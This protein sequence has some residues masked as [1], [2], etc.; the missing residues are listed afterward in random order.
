[1]SISNSLQCEGFPLLRNRDDLRQRQRPREIGKR[2]LDLIISTLALIV[3]AP[4]LLCLWAAIR[5]DSPGPAVFRQRRVGRGEKQF[6]CFK[7]RTMHYKADEDLHRE[8]IH[9]LWTG[10][11]ISND[12]DVPYKIADDPRT[13]RVGRWLRRTSLDELPQL[14]NVLRGEMSLVGPRPAI[15][16][17]LQYFGDCRQKRHEVK[18][19]ITGVW[20]VR[21]RA[22]VPPA[23]MLAMD[24]EYAMTWSI[25]TD[26]KLI[27]LT[28]PAVLMR[29]GAR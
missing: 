6:I 15:P 11:R 5:L 23:A 17:E 29:Y 13:T 18:P 3:L 4:V 21:G 9:R 26:L 1:M 20:Q 16:Y 10:G 22:C 2:T 27:V 19:G 28:I 12:A 14:V 8:A 24:V 25:W 7:F